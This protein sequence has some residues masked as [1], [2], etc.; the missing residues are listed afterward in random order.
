MGLPGCVCSRYLNSLVH[1][2]TVPVPAAPLRAYRFTSA[3]GRAAAVEDGV[4]IGCIFKIGFDDKDG[5]VYSNKVV[6]MDEGHHLTRPHPFYHEQLS[7][8]RRL[9]GAMVVRLAN[10][11]AAQVLKVHR[12]VTAGLFHF[13]WACIF[14]TRNRCAFAAAVVGAFVLLCV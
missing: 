12:T 6:I 8:L 13:I 5:N 14:G 10:E 3:G 9:Q 1:D 11:T 7:N 4:L 2:D